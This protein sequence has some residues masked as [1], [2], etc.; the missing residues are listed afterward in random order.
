MAT[1]CRHES[2]SVQWPPCCRR[3]GKPRI[4]S[5]KRKKLPL[6]DTSAFGHEWATLQNNHEHYE[7]SCLLVKLSGIAVFIACLALSL[8]LV[9]TT[10][11]MLI[12]WLQEAIL[13]TSQSRLGDRILRI[14]QLLEQGGALAAPAYRLHS[15]WLAARPGFAGLL[16]EYGRNMLRPTVAFPYVVL[17]GIT[18]GWFLF[19]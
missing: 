13:R 3:Q 11:L 5:E 2:A 17:V 15:E 12:M 1:Q 19:G 7:K 18:G 6:P 10:L 16:A 14:E 4:Q 9:V 8:D